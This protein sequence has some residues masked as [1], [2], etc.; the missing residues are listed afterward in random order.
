M[1]HLAQHAQVLLSGF[2]GVLGVFEGGLR[3][4]RLRFSFALCLL[5]ADLR[6]LEL[7]PCLPR[8]HLQR[9]TRTLSVC[10]RRFDLRTSLLYLLFDFARVDTRQ[11]LPLLHHRAFVDQQRFD[12]SGHARLD[13]HHAHRFHRARLADLHRDFAALDGKSAFTLRRA[14]LDSCA[15]YNPARARTDDDTGK[16]NGASPNL[17]LHRFFVPRKV[18]PICRYTLPMRKEGYCA[19]G[20]RR[21]REAVQALQVQMDALAG[22]QRDAITR[23]L[24]AAHHLQTCLTLFRVCYPKMRVA[25]WKRR[26]RRLLRALNKQSDFLRTIEWINTLVPPPACRAGVRRAL[27]RL[28]QQAEAQADTIRQ[29]WHEWL[30]SCAP[31][32]ILGLSRRWIESFADEP[33]DRAFAQH[34]WTLF[35]REQS[36]ALQDDTGQSLAVRCGRLRTLL[37]GCALLQPLLDCQPDNVWRELYD[38]LEHLRWQEETKQA[39]ERL[40][41]LEATATLWLLGHQRGLSRLRKGWEWLIQALDEPNA[42]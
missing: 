41:M 40:W 4:S 38:T 6:L 5:I 23:A 3:E 24:G 30:S 27:L 34:Q 26:L 33:C 12:P 16:S 42:L 15:C 7:Q 18:Y 22:N 29:S 36:S 1:L 32:E 37:E 39:L 2:E 20:A 13:L 8:L 21:T 31:N 14:C 28:T 17:L 11:Q 10:L 25:F 19:Y 35:A 9:D